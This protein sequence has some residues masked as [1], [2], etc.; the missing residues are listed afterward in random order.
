MS[1][2]LNIQNYGFKEILDLFNLQYNFNL[3][4]LKIAKKVVLRTH[5]DKS[6]LPSE[7]FLFYKKA[8]DIILEYYNNNHKQNNVVPDKEIIYDSNNDNYDET[9]NKHVSKVINNI[10]KDEFNNKFNDL[11]DN[12]MTSKINTEKNKWF[13]EDNNDFN[14]KTQVNSNNMSQVFNQLKNQGHGLVKYNGVQNLYINS[15]SGSQLYDDDDN[16]NYITNDPFSKLK[17]DDLRKVHKNETIFSVSE[18]DINKVTKYNSV[19]EYMHARGNQNTIPLEKQHAEQLLQQQYD[20][21]QKNISN[22]YHKAQLDTMTYTQKNKE[23]LSTFL[24]IKN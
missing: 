8:F 15:N 16:D 23:I 19:D 4:E 24:Q 2:N 17:F 11:F 5:P 9:T 7:Y 18:N 13:H 3:E 20:C 6:K 12:N 14:I 1:H 22:K 10:N 21:K